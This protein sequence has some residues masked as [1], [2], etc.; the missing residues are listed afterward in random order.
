MI[1]NLDEINEQ[2]INNKLYDTIIIGSGPAGLS[3]AYA[4]QKSKKRIAVI[5]AGG[6]NYS[7]KSL[8]P[9]KGSIVGDKYFDLQYARQ[10]F[11]GGTSNHWSGWC[12]PLDEHDFKEKNYQ[13]LASWPITRKD[14][15]PYLN[16]ASN[17]LEIDSEY[18]DKVLN[19]EYGVKKISFKFSPPV[20]F[21][22]K[23][24]YLFNESNLDLFL[25]SNLVNFDKVGDSI[26]SATFKSYKSNEI[27]LNAKT[28]I[29][30]TG[31]IENSRLMLAI[32]QKNNLSL[33]NKA[34][35]I[36]KY[37]MEHPP[38]TI[39]DSIIPKNWKNRFLAL[40]EQKQREL[41]ILNC[42]IRFEG[43]IASTELKQMIKDV[44]C[45]APD[46]G[47]KLFD[48]MDRQLICGGKIRA[49]WE[50]AP[51]EK[52]KISLSNDEKDIFGIP[53]PVLHYKKTN[54]DKNTVF[55]TIKQIAYYGNHL[56]Y[57]RIKLFDF[58]S[59]LGN[60]PENDEL[61]GYHHMGGTR[62]SKSPNK[63]VV[64]SNLKVHGINNLYIA[65]SSVFPSGGHANPTLT[66]VQ[67]SLR[68]AEH[69]ETI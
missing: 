47:K 45:Y 14:L 37:W 26:S 46:I 63:G 13:K 59:S 58:V 65:G 56:S 4:L 6:E 29:L 69:I 38:F 52:N 53:R 49:A 39:G 62:M 60:Y 54:F 20:R 28:F 32:N 41:G 10:R 68:L 5:E 50:Q 67:L 16:K 40:T 12:R 66:I 55:Q 51:F 17:I 57:G 3:L 7:T 1:Y 61:A 33:F 15:E 22:Q 48:M 42:G 36:G 43:G 19:N 24:K 31:G 2:F 30:A 18:D 35:P 8:E 34:M 64:D 9:Y 25:N 23:Y 44:A 21:G 11:F 27:K